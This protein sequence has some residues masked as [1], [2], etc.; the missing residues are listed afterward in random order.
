MTLEYMKYFL[1]CGCCSELLWDGTAVSCFYITF[2]VWLIRK[3]DII[4]LQEIMR[5][6]ADVECLASHMWSLKSSPFK[7]TQYSNLKHFY[8][9]KYQT[10]SGFLW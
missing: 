1:A 10:I 8:V 5:R 7:N 3:E 9:V 6:I 2:V 4:D